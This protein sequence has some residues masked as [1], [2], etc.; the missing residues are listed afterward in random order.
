MNKNGDMVLN[1]I[2]KPILILILIV[3]VLAWAGP[4]YSEIREMLGFQV[5]LTA[6][7]QSTQDDSVEFVEDVLISS[8]YDC[9]DSSK[10]SCFCEVEGFSFPNDY[11]LNFYDDAGDMSLNFINN[12]G[13]KFLEKWIGDVT[14]CFDKN[15]VFLEFPGNIKDDRI[16]LF[17]SS[18]VKISS[19]EG[20]KNVN[21]DYVF[22]KPNSDSIC[23]VSEEILFLKGGGDICD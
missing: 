4:A 13:G 18:N 23:I 7:E 17:F 2:V 14:P 9:R 21:L 16:T 6:E 1:S 19:D 8:L 11:S 12:Q 20:L 5:S 10:K 3:V 15:G 22:Y